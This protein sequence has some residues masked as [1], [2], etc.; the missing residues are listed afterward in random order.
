MGSFILAAS[1]DL[2]VLQSNI[3][4]TLKHN[5]QEKPA[6]EMSFISR[7]KW[8]INLLFNLKG[9]NW[10]CAAP[11][12]RYPE[13][14]SRWRFVFSQLLWAGFYYLLADILCIYTRGHPAFTYPPTEVFGSRGLGWQAVNVMIFWTLAVSFMSRNHATLAAVTVAL[15]MYDPQDWPAFFGVWSRTKSIRAF[16]GRSWHQSL[17][18]SIQPQSKYFTNKVLGFPPKS[19]QST[20]T[21]LFLCFFLSGVYHAAG[22][23]LVQHNSTTALANINFFVMQ[24]C[25]ITLEDFI[26]FVGKRLGISRIPSVISY[27]WVVGWLTATC[28]EW[29]EA[30][31]KGDTLKF[32]VGVSFVGI[33]REILAV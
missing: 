11:G 17:R 32:E 13:S 23:W 33:V 1:F 31:I 24:A 5:N 12:I 18:R 19:L 15:G 10:N 6:S 2:L 14:T 26:T 28:P 8:G 20:Y 7:L 29:M 21:Q 22:D 27:L 4:E 25:V 30:S 16:W 9:S 3:Q